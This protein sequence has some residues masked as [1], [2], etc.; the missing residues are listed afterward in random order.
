MYE[1]GASSWICVRERESDHYAVTFDQ[2]FQI[3]ISMRA[4]FNL[5][6]KFIAFFVYISI[7]FFT[8]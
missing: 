4:I 2:I 6:L 7:V 8:G 1:G 3:S 5:V